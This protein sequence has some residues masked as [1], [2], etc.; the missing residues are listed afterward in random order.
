MS[1]A[2]QAKR[3]ADFP[4]N[5]SG[6]GQRWKMEIQTARK[7]L[8]PWHKDGDEAVKRFLDDRS[9]ELENVKALCRL[10]IY[11]ANVQTLRALLYGQVPKADATRRWGD[12]D[13]DVARIGAVI[14]DRLLNLDIEEGDTYAEAIGSALDDRQIPGLGIVRLRYTAKA[15]P[16]TGEDG[17]PVLDEEGKP[18]ERKQYECVE[19]DYVY[20]KDFLWSP[21]RVWSEVRWV[22]QLLR[23]TREDCIEKFG[24]KLGKVIPLNGSKRSTDDDDGLKADPWARAEV[25]E[26]W[27]K[28]HKKRFYLCEDYP[29]ILGQ[30]KDPLGLKRFFPF[31]RPMMA[32]LTTA[33]LIPTPDFKLNKSLFDQID[34]VNTKIKL[35]VD[36]LRLV[37]FYDASNEEL[38]RALDS[39]RGNEM[40]PVENFAALSEKGGIR[41]VV[42]WFPLDMVVA[43]L[44]KLREVRA[45]LIGLS[46]QTT[47]MSDIMRGQSAEPGVTAREQSI[48]ARF[49]SV[50]VQALQDDFA[51][52]ATEALRIK[53]EIIAKQFDPETIKTQSNIMSTKDGR[54]RPD[55]VDAAIALIK[56]RWA[57]DYRIEV[58]PQSI[59][60]SDYAADQAEG[61]QLIQAISAA[62]Q[63]LVPMAQAMPGSTPYAL[64][65]VKH[66]LARFPG[67][68]AIEGVLDRATDAATQQMQQPQEQPPDPKMQAAQ[69]KLQGE[70]M[71]GQME[72]Q[73]VQAELQA[74][75]TR[76]AA[77]TKAKGSEEAAQ[78]YWAVKEEADKMALQRAH[79][80]PEEQL[81]GGKL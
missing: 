43:S 29:T 25:W 48:K 39:N 18:H 80:T 5:P 51:R 32:N 49:A 79:M 14:L 81:T 76:I 20:W 15:E 67:A 19:T 62:I 57:M 12:S 66:A 11:T 37:G 46:Q 27:S 75:L 1:Q 63:A 13:D 21:A 28:Q 38:K 45:E 68:D 17:K 16:F 6:W 56:D 54:D 10:N 55:L 4:D 65:I 61:M 24:E 74:D 30:D 35:L 9:G 58:K 71:K 52:F 53:Q 69:M 3:E 33:Q 42:D 31:P 36:G 50:R 78:A 44:D 47:G 34:T 60:I 23:L 8:E 59:S 2:V 72:M 64:E 77:Q 73:K 41:G 26:I 40:I 7:A 22:G 70:Q